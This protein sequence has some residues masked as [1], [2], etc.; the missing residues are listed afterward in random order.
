MAGVGG[1]YDP[2]FWYRHF[3]IRTE[4]EMFDTLGKFAL[5]VGPPGVK[6]TPEAFTAL[7]FNYPD[8]PAG[9]Y[10]LAVAITYFAFGG[11]VQKTQAAA[12]QA[13]GV[14]HERQENEVAPL[15]IPN[16]YRV[17]IEGISGSQPVVNVVGV[18]GSSPG[19]AAAAAAAVKAAWKATSSFHSRLSSYYQLQNV[20][21]MDLSSVDGE[22]ADV[23]DSANGGQ[24]TVA[25]AT[26]GACALVKW[27]GGTRSGSSRG[28]MYFGPITESVI[29][30]DGRTLAS[31][32]VTSLTNAANNF[33]NSLSGAGFPLVVISQKQAKAT[34]V[35]SAAVESII[36]SQRR[37]I[38]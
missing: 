6:A 17:A 26:N 18:R 8:T 5:V 10:M 9:G 35:T 21:A 33:I 19:Q 24:G 2:G 20:H 30:A 22:I 12:N 7:A 34:T 36:A 31:A 25:L 23:G 29:N 38:R 14:F 32:E 15:V 37:R 27:N 11:D 16:V 1:T 28:R 13:A 3:G 4:Q